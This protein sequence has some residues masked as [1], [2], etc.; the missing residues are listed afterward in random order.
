MVSQ[1]ILYKNDITGETFET[2]LE[3]VDSE[4]R[5]L[6]ASSVQRGEFSERTEDW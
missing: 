3:A 5:S 4:F 6:H 1:T 2:K